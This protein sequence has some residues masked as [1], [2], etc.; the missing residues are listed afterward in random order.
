MAKIKLNKSYSS[1]GEDQKIN[2]ADQVRRDTDTIK[3]PTCTIYDVD[4]AIISYLRE[5]VH[6]QIEEDGL[7]IDVPIMYANGEK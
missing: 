2:R 3:T 4:Y 5:V 7:K 1:A 6:P